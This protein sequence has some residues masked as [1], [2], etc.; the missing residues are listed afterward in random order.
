[1]NIHEIK[2]QIKDLAEKHLAV[3][4]PELYD[5][6]LAVEFLEAQALQLL[7]DYCEE[8]GYEIDGFPTQKRKLIEEEDQDEDEYFTQERYELYICL[9]TLEKEDVA[10]LYWFYQNSFWPDYHESQMDFIQHLKN[11][12]ESGFFQIEF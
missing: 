4:M 7:I 9:L 10:E 1:M 8:K 11:Q 12:I 6:M 5:E 3:Q 2:R